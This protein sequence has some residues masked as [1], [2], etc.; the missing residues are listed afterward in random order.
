MN[1]TFISI[2]KAEEMPAV[3]IRS[4]SIFLFLVCLIIPVRGQSLSISARFD[5]TSMRIGEQTLFTVTVEQPAGMYVSFPEF[6]DTLTTGIEVLQAHPSDT[7][8]IDEQNLQITRS[9]RVTSFEPGHH[10]VG[11]IPFAF[12]LDDDERVLTARPSALKV[13]APDIDREAGIYDIKAPFA[14][15]LSAREILTWILVAVILAFLL[16]YGIRILRKKK[17]DEPGYQPGKPLEPAHV[18]A[19]KE[20][21]K[22]KSESLWQNGMVKE[23]YTRLTGIIRKY[24]ERRFGITAMERTSRE[25]ITELNSNVTLPKEVIALLEQCF[26]LADLVKFAKARPGEEYHEMSLNT[27]FRFVK[28]TCS[29]GPGTGDVPAYAGPNGEAVEK[30]PAGINERQSVNRNDAP[31][32]SI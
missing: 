31:D 11:T 28:A 15:S 5:T 9:W 27:G 8:M 14:V 18:T 7:I 1:R 16:W 21:K 20:L 29:P 6:T 13:L 30:D 10:D 3:I 23:Y 24:I 19:L 12:L 4:L 32:G 2:S 17:V 22:L 25:I 26:Y